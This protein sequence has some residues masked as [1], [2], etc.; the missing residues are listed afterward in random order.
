M[1]DTSANLEAWAALHE[2]A[3]YE[4]IRTGLSEVI[5]LLEQPGLGL[6]ESVRAYEIGRQLA[7]RCQVLLDEAEL[8]ISTLDADVPN[9][10]QR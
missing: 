2:S 7:H 10:V 5:A 1:T 8:R 3:D 9:D 4:T 6:N